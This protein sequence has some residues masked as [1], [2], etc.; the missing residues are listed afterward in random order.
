MTTR[1]MPWPLPALL[2]W[3]AC[4]LAHLGLARLGAGELAASTLP[5]LLGVGLAVPGTT[6]WRRVFIG[7]GFPLSFAATGTAGA[8]PGWAWL[9]PLAL[10]AGLYPVR[11]WR[12]APLFP[13]P[14]GALAG[15]ARRVALAPGARALDAGCGL[16]AGLVALRDEYPRAAI[17]GIEWSWLL[18]LLCAARCRFA[19]VRQG[20]LWQ[21]DWSGYALVYLFQRPE[22]M[23]RAGHKAG[24]EL[25]RGAWLASL[26]FRIPDLAPDHV[27][28]GDDRR[29]VYLYRAPF[30]SA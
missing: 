2:A 8:L 18:R 12:D 26:E 1:L 20:D 16:G 22:S 19:R 15:M 14:D 4:W 27:I 6:P 23:T 10:L 7:A 9:L 3:T 5:L 25:A 30:R 29:S 13:T 28:D 24:C 17:E 21:T 11:A